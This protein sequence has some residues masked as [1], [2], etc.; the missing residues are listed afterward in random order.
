MKHKNL[1]G[2]LVAFAATAVLSGQAPASTLRRTA[3]IQQGGAGELGVARNA[4]TECIRAAIPALDIPPATADAVAR[5]AMHSCSEKYSDM[6]QALTRTLEPTCGQDSKC[7]QAA[8]AR[9]DRDAIRA[10]VEEVT[11]ERIRVANA[12]VLKC[13]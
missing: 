5:A 6:T 12:Q 3:D 4:W 8:L 11:A 1:I 9:A 13:Q 7:T 2:M 10:A